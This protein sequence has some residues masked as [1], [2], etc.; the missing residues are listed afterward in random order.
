[1]NFIKTNLSSLQK[2]IKNASSLCERNPESIQILAV[3]KKHSIDL[4]KIANGIKKAINVLYRGKTALGPPVISLQIKG[5]NVSKT[6][7]K[8]LR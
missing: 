2:R 8:I 7:K 1:M 3:S 5:D 6:I 4:I